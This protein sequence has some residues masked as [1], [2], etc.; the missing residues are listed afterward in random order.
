MFWDFEQ[1]EECEECHKPDSIADV[2]TV[3][4]ITSFS[5]S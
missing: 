5:A 2:V 3:A 1:D 4:N